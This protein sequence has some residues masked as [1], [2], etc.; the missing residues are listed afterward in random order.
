MSQSISVTILV[1]NSQK[2][3]DACLGA[4]QDFEEIIVL[5]NGSTDNSIAIASSYANVKVYSSPFIGFGP[6]KNLAAQYA[7]NPWVLSIDS[8]E[9]LSEELRAE[10]RQLD[11][12]DTGKVYS[13]K[14]N[15]YYRNKLIN[16]CG[17][18]NDYVQRLYNKEATRFADLQVHEYVRTEGLQVQRLKGSIA[19]FSYDSISQL[20]AK[21]DKYTTLFATE[22]RFVKKSS[23]FKSYYK[24]AFSF[25]RSYVLQRG[26]LLGYEG[27]TISFTNAAY[28]FYKYMKLHEANQTLDMS[29]V[30]IQPLDCKVWESIKPT[31]QAQEEVLQVLILPEPSP[32]VKTVK[33]SNSFSPVSTYAVTD[34]EN[35][36]AILQDIIQASTGEY[37]ILMN[38]MAAL[39]TDFLKKIKRTA[40]KGH[41]TSG[42]TSSKDYSFIAFWK[43]DFTKLDFSEALV[44]DT[45]DSLAMISAMLQQHGIKPVRLI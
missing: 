28:S 2:H 40:R 41:Y 9:V 33:V 17:W 43:E 27:L 39:G 21:A 5:D 34:G 35:N 16:G 36:A 23:A 10:I 4:L 25:F 32:G 19:H 26:F 15:N 37:F 7:S 42:E 31:F 20:I 11:L 38:N 45:A 8:D 13:I 30:V 12:A 44:R 29:M 14:R 6:L 24:W 22:K 3:L 18:D 1:K